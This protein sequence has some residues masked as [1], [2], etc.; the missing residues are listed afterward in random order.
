MIR[1]KQPDAPALP[2]LRLAPQGG[3]LPSGKKGVYVVSLILNCLRK[4]ASSLDNTTQ[5]S[6]D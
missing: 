1:Q 2:R 6:E 4:G 5:A 3:T